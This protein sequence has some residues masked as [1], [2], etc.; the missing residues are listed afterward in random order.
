MA[1]PPPAT[2]NIDAR[3]KRIFDHLYANGPVRTPSALAGEVGKLIR[4]A[5]F[6]ERATGAPAAFAFPQTLRRALAARSGEAVRAVASEVRARYA[7]MNAAWGV[8]AGEGLLLS[9]EDVAWC[10]AELDGARLSS[11]ARDVFGDAVEIFRTSW[12]KQSSG[13]FFTDGEVT[14]LAMT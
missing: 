7:E 4:T 6:I 14:H 12:A 8:Y 5:T 2:A 3:F 13:Q 1:S 10:C 9:D 11:E